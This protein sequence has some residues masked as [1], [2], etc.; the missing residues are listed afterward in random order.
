[1]GEILPDGHHA[2]R[3]AIRAVE[4]LRI[5][6][7]WV[8][9]HPARRPDPAKDAK[10]AVMTE[11]HKYETISVAERARPLQVWVTGE[12]LVAEALFRGRR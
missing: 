10:G 8:I 6:I 5:L 2:A 4:A 11:R 7:R 1:V 12:R 3:E 9:L